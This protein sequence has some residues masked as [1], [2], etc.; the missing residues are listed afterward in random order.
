MRRSLSL[1]SASGRES[2]STNDSASSRSGSDETSAVTSMTQ[3]YSVLVGLNG[4]EEESSEEDV[5]VV[6]PEVETLSRRPRTS[7][8]PSSERQ[9]QD[10]V[11]VFVRV[12]SRTHS[13]SLFPLLKTSSS[14]ASS[15]GKKTVI[16]ISSVDRRVTL[17]KRQGTPLLF[18]RSMA[19]KVFPGDDEVNYV[20]DGVLGSQDRSGIEDVSDQDVDDCIGRNMV[21]KAVSGI[22][23]C[24]LTYGSMDNSDHKSLIKHFLQDLFTRELAQ[25][26]NDVNSRPNT[27]GEDRDC[28]NAF[29]A[30]Q[31][32]VTIGYVE[33]FD[34]NVYD[35][36]ENDAECTIPKKVVDSP[37]MGVYIKNLK[38]VPAANLE[39]ANELLD[40]ALDKRRVQQN[41]ATRASSRSSNSPASAPCGD[42]VHTHGICYIEVKETGEILTTQ[43]VTVLRS[44][45]TFAAVASDISASQ[46]SDG[47]LRSRPWG[48]SSIL[49][50]HESTLRGT[51]SDQS[52][53]AST[54]RELADSKVYID[55]TR[56]HSV[57]TLSRVVDAIA[58]VSRDP[59]STR[60]PP[61][62]ESKLSLLLKNCLAGNTKTVLLANVSPFP[63][64][65]DQTLA[66]L[67]FASRAREMTNQRPRLNRDPKIPRILDLQQEIQRIRNN[68]AASLDGETRLIGL[69][70]YEE[71]MRNLAFQ[72][73]VKETKM[74]LE[75]REGSISKHELDI[76]LTRHYI[77]IAGE[78]LSNESKD[79]LS[80]AHLSARMRNM[81]KDS[82]NSGVGGENSLSHLG[83]EMSFKAEK[84]QEKV[85]QEAGA[86][87]EIE[88]HQW[89]LLFELMRG[90]TA[91]ISKLY[92]EQIVAGHNQLQNKKEEWNNTAKEVRKK[93]RDLYSAYKTTDAKYK[94]AASSFKEL[95]RIREDMKKLHSKM[96]VSSRAKSPSKS[97]STKDDPDG[98]DSSKPDSISSEMLTEISQRLDKVV[99]ETVTGNVAQLDLEKRDSTSV[100]DA[101]N[102]ALAEAEARHTETLQNA[103]AM[104]AEKYDEVVEGQWEVHTQAM[105]RLADEYERAWV[106]AS[107]EH[108][109]KVQ[110][111]IM[112]ATMASN[113]SS[114]SMTSVNAPPPIMPPKIPIMRTK[115][116][117]LAKPKPGAVDSGTV[118]VNVERLELETAKTLKPDPAFVPPSGSSV[119]GD[120]WDKGSTT[121]SVAGSLDSGNRSFYIGDPTSTLDK[122][123][124]VPHPPAHDHE[125][126]RPSRRKGA[127]ASQVKSNF[128]AE[129]RSL[130]ALLE[131]CA[132]LRISI[133]D[134]FGANPG[135]Q[136]VDPS[137]I[138]PKGMKLS[139][140]IRKRPP[141]PT[142]LAE[143][144]HELHLLEEDLIASNPTINDPD[145]Q[146]PQGTKLFLQP[147]QA[148]KQTTQPKQAHPPP[149]SQ[150]KD[151][152]PRHAVA[153]VN[154]APPQTLRIIC[155]KLNIS[156]N[157]LVRV[158]GNLLS[159]DPDARLPNGLKVSIVC[160]KK[161]KKKELQQMPSHNSEHSFSTKEEET[162]Y[163]T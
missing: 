71:E 129:P 25:L 76:L 117:R 98:S 11:E 78:K 55:N 57:R 148:P 152:S 51:T 115:K 163:V 82:N 107:E 19:T 141:P 14:S 31:W 33:V 125:A 121:M 118:D 110:G 15:R 102:A 63:T 122:S 155:A 156:M 92:L 5:K 157:T 58:S 53:F 126:S 54:L 162:T 151:A 75:M 74:M 87:H 18:Q 9:Q 158:T 50:S 119:A 45:T 127:I 84:L 43:R 131:L 67:R 128:G 35:L 30:R 79:E 143:V 142:T 93:Y 17:F 114:K 23:S 135:L 146:L 56:Q 29:S 13:D 42:S 34:E 101:V 39:E 64:D 145:A 70:L 10:H 138:L 69:R 161:G 40:F 65:Y 59:K 8:P 137:A 37:T 61:F 89:S 41:G 95:E 77:A 130:R 85:R 32:T 108:S 123:S 1:D 12:R 132:S 147:E 83:T 106:A 81:H 68:T 136:W 111:Y 60:Q 26:R 133:K 104:Q 73:S 22:N 96:A 159:I 139:F 4:N 62:S 91:V 160:K 103:L 94:A 120:K 7:L 52:N 150:K 44:M 72:L 20:F 116:P 97:E 154:S 112:T 105:E 144:A 49:G 99:S 36:M 80:E 109:T 66:T 90:H 88:E 124:R 6:T 47:V 3:T 113:V 2:S 86:R 100:T 28:T 27:D 24:L 38:M 153:G 134:L 21:L 16:E 149:T 48:L 140:A 46:Q